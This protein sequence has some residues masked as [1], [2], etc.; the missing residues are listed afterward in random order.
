[1]PIHGIGMQAH[2]SLGTRPQN[3][4]DSIVRFAELGVQVHIT[5]MD[6]TVGPAQGQERLNEAQEMAQAVLYAQLFRIFRD[7]SDV[8]YR[9]TVW[10]ICD[11]T[12]WRANRFPLLFNSDL[13]AKLALHAILDPDA[14]LAAQGLD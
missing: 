14:F 3:V 6:I 5:E 12:S 11:G 10:G 8:I 2:Y 13:S 1:V 9:V 4:E 7:H